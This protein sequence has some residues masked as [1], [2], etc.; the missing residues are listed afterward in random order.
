MRV[1]QDSNVLIAKGTII[2]Q[3]E[4]VGSA[5]PRAPLKKIPVTELCKEI[6]SYLAE[7]DNIIACRAS[8]SELPYEDV[9]RAKWHALAAE[10]FWGFVEQALADPD[11]L[12]FYRD[13]L[14]YVE[15][16]NNMHVFPEDRIAPFG[17]RFADLFPLSVSFSAGSLHMVWCPTKLHHYPWVFGQCRPG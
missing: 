11:F 15:L 3:I 2:D 16:K 4:L 6:L 14:P 13:F 12:S 8:P 10:S 1:A 5:R 17:E 7:L 9:A